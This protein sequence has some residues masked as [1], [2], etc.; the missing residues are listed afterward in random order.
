MEKIKWSKMERTRTAILN[1][2]NRSLQDQSVQT[3]TAPRDN[4]ERPKDP[5]GADLPVHGS[6]ND[7][8]HHLIHSNKPCKTNEH[9]EDPSGQEFARTGELTANT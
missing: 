9:R 5:T 3:E 8:A 7:A 2:D 4:V 1:A 6:C